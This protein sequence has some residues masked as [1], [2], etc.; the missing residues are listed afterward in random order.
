MNSPRS[1]RLCNIFV[2]AISLVVACKSEPSPPATA[3]AGGSATSPSADPAA[4]RKKDYDLI[5]EADQCA[6]KKNEPEDWCPGYDENFDPAKDPGTLLPVIDKLSPTDWYPA[7]LPGD[8]KPK[9]GSVP[10][11]YGM[12]VLVEGKRIPLQNMKSGGIVLAR[13]TAAT[14]TP[15]DARYGITGDTQFE[16]TFY[17]VV[18]NYKA[19]SG[20][21][22]PDEGQRI[23][24]WRV[25]GV[26]KANG[27]TG[28][29]LVYVNKSGG[30]F[31][32]CKL[33]HSK[34]LS[35]IGGAFVRCNEPSIM[36]TL[37]SSAP[38]L[39]SKWSKVSSELSKRLGE[40]NAAPMEPARTKNLV[41]E[42]FNANGIPTSGLTDDFI[43]QLTGVLRTSE[44]GPAWLRCGAGCCTADN[45]I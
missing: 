11:V 33:R 2:A 31:R 29:S 24:T 8:H 20:D 10:S 36:M 32:Y 27:S 4:F 30:K 44:E 39:L 19:E 1:P 45:V 23:A 16:P 17:L 13:F 14:T 18:D 15:E 7:V 37:E 34:E 6:F 25:V 12:D 41:I 40:S 35:D 26:K 22:S 5:G 38:G 42:V 28:R 3:G 21:I 9:T 43:K